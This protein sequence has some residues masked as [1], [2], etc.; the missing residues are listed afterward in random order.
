MYKSNLKIGNECPQCGS[1][2]SMEEADWNRCGCCGYPEEDVTDE[3]IEE[4]MGDMNTPEAIK[5]WNECSAYIMKHKM[6]PNL[7]FPEN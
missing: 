4:A 5:E 6:Q 2:M 1:I 7:D 3:Q